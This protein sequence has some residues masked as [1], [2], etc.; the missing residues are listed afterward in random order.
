M[1]AGGCYEVPLLSFFPS[2]T[3]LPSATQSEN[4]NKNIK[5]SN[6]R[7]PSHH[8]RAPSTPSQSRY[9]CISMG[10]NKGKWRDA[11][12]TLLV[13]TSFEQCWHWNACQAEDGSGLQAQRKSLSCFWPQ[14]KR[15]LST[16][17]HYAIP[18]HWL[19][20]QFTMY[21]ELGSTTAS[22]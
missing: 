13:A 3:Y 22:V 21:Y 19:G 12:R 17:L 15:G 8:R 10:R 14:P 2:H 1:A 4:A 11:G 20:D 18:W 9:Q 5:P 6:C 16:T 7:C